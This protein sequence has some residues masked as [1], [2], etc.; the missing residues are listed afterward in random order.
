MV[1]DISRT[2][3]L[4]ENA[5]EHLRVLEAQYER[6]PED[7]AQEIALG[8]MRNHVDD[9]QQQLAH[10]KAQREV[11]VVELRLS[12][13]K[14]Q[15]GTL[16][17]DLLGSLATHIARFLYATASRH[18]RGLEA[19][20][21]FREE[22]KEMLGLRFG[23]LAAGSTRV[24][25]T[26]KTNPDILGRSLLEDTLETTFSLLT[27]FQQED[28]LMAQ[29]HALGDRGTKKLT[30]LI[31]ALQK[32]QLEASILWRA[33]D[34]SKYEWTANATTIAALSDRLHQISA[35]TREVIQIEGIVHL[36]GR[37]GRI[38]VDGGQGNVIRAT[39]PQTMLPRVQGLRI[40]QRLSA[41]FN[42]TRVTNVATGA[43]RDYYDLRE[44]DDPAA[45]QLET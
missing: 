19:R 18:E 23:G 31:D 9:L 25:I 6:A 30:N 37:N 43:S 41:L 36:I 32:A 4:L 21:P 13:Q 12:G 40:G 14:A 45:S 17:L 20:G 16:P 24:F 8:S 34:H 38:E 28:A 29:V 10:A 5:T 33:P 39:F 42:R 1:V 2:E 27:D 11:E 44:I 22:L 26:G 35:Q 7:F 3:N 15:N